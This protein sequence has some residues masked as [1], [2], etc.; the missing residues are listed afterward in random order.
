MTTYHLSIHKICDSYGNLDT[1]SSRELQ[2]DNKQDFD[3]AKKLCENKKNMAGYL[4]QSVLPIRTDRAA[5]LFLP[6]LMNGVVKT[7]DLAENFFAVIA[8][9]IWDL[10][11]LPVRSLTYFPRMAYNARVKPEPHPLISYLKG[12]GYCGVHVEGGAPCEAT[13]GLN[14]KWV[15]R[16]GEKEG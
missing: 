4:K 5:D 15:L 2:L 1:F 6:T 7:K 11:T 8:A 3:H 10:A 13:R 14:G 12:K 16:E 9:I